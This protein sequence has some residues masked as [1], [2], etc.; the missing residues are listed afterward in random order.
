MSAT[1]LNVGHPPRSRFCRNFFLEV[2]A[3]KPLLVP[4]PPEEL[5]VFPIEPLVNNA[6]N[7][8]R[9]CREQL[10]CHTILPSGLTRDPVGRIHDQ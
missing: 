4:S 9:L 8:F 1:P 2:E 3:F 7:D 6:Q 5:E 10:Q